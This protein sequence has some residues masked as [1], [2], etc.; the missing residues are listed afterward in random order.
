MRRIRVSALILAVLGGA[1]L[2]ACNFVLGLGGYANTGG[3][4][5]GSNASTGA[6]ATDGGGGD[7]ASDGDAARPNDGGQALW[8]AQ[9]SG[10]TVHA[11]AV[12]ADGSVFVTG[13]ASGPAAFDCTSGPDGGPGAGTG[14]VVQLDGSSGKCSWG[15]FFGDTPGATGTGVAVASTG[16]V[17]I[18]GYFTDTATVLPGFKMTAGMTDS[19][20]ALLDASSAHLPTWAV[21]I[22]DQTGPTMV[23]NQQT[24]AVALR[25]GTVAVSGTYTVSLA[26]R[27]MMSGAPA[28]LT[29]AQDT[30]DGFAM[31]FTGGSSSPVQ[32]GIV[33]QLPSMD[34]NFANG[35]SIDSA[36][37]V[38]FT[39]TTVGSA[40]FTGLPTVSVTSNDG[41]IFLASYK[42]ASTGKFATVL[43]GLLAQHGVSV[44]FD[45]TDSLLVG[46]DF[47]GT[48][49]VE[50]GGAS[51]T[52]QGTNALVA[53]FDGDG[54]AQ[55]SLQLGSVTQGTIVT[56]AGV[57]PWPVPGFPSSTSPNGPSV[58]LGGSFIGGSAS[59]VD[60]G[61]I[62]PNPGDQPKIYVAKVTSTLGEIL[63]AKTFGD[64]TMAQSVNAVAVDPRDGSVLVAGQFAGDLPLEGDAGTLPAGTAPD[65]FVAKLTP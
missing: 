21:Q 4:G 40:I 48:V 17:A 26:T 36:S 28:P 32:V 49:G 52:A 24:T 8:G 37:N 53:Y 7:A 22:T 31:W 18:T 3:S 47:A 30:Q 65:M 12:A 57:A 60:A 61:P 9:F 58:A 50:D 27:P 15:F 42:L 62:L 1:T 64:G 34:S 23:G 41:N 14:F 16:E 46:G 33:N 55:A 38:A 54:G 19:F 43:S 20:V 29:A 6:G 2:A 59:F 45:T 44:A 13:N 5:G 35:V 11:M 63:W 51:Y 10:A 56:L 39:G 25:N